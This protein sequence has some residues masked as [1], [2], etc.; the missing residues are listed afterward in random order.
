MHSIT[1]EVAIVGAGTAG[2]FIASLLDNAGID[3]VVI[4]KSRGLGGRCS[5]RR[6]SNENNTN[7]GIDLGAPEFSS[8]KVTH[9]KLNDM[10]D[11][12]E[13][14][15]H[16]SKWAKTVGRFDN[17]PSATETVTT[18]CGV[19]SMNAWH[20][21]IAGHINILTQNRVCSLARVDH[22]W[23]LFDENNEPIA[24]TNKLVITAPP[25][26]TRDLLNTAKG[27]AN[28]S[29]PDTLPQES[30]PQYVCAIG[31]SSSL[32]LDADVYE[33]GHL[34]LHRAIRE[35]SKPGRICPAPLEEVW[36]LHSSFEWAQAQNHAPSDKVALALANT[37]CH[38]FGIKAKPKVLTSH[39]WRM[40]KY[41]STSHK[42]TT[43][44]WHSDFNVG[45]CG[46]W[47]GRGGTIG[48]LNSAFALHEAIL[49]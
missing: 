33:S 5:R 44:I 35:N 1:A 7:Y 27:L 36:V 2:C 30:L 23:H 45:C 3:C 8:G 16:V 29:L 42:N 49:K 22:R 12:W 39:Y 9:P 31:F 37:F 21:N 38:H 10:I 41:R 40:A 25:E 24:V 46:D 48:A 18:L 26:Q 6:I 34:S 19:P 43:F 28:F 15:G 4:E 11:S 14:A 20:S 13:T 47:L 32:G 17:V